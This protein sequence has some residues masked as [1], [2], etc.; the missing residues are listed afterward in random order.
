MARRFL[1]PAL[2]F[3][4]VA[5]DLG[6]N[7][8]AAVAVLF[9]AIPAAFVLA[10]DCYGDALEARCTLTRPILAALSLFLIVLSTALRSEAV[11]GG[12][13]AIAVSSL[14]FALVVY[15]VLGLGV[16]VRVTAPR[17]RQH[18]APVQ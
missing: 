10:L 5:L 14:V 17:R 1:P 7:H 9:V 8:R 18:A 12:V 4:A 11:V 6:D 2:A 3:V 13:P 16:A 15:A